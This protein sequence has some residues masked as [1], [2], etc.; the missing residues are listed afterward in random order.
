MTTQELLLKELWVAKKSI[1]LN[2]TEFQKLKV[3][4]SFLGK[5]N[6]ALSFNLKRKIVIFNISKR[7]WHQRWVI[8]GQKYLL[9]NI[10]Q[11]F[12]RRPSRTEAINELHNFLVSWD[13]YNWQG[14]PNFFMLMEFQ[15]IFAK[16]EIAPFQRGNWTLL[17]ISKRKPFWRI[18][19]LHGL[20]G[21]SLLQAFK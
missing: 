4:K 6:S 16:V 12:Y 18:L 15:A 3:G 9:Y 21:V 2:K 17:C 10:F 19:V 7:R 20:S 14:E 8:H 5:R 1:L 13:F 11:R